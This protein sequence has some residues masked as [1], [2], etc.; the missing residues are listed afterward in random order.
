[1]AESSRWRGPE[2]ARDFVQALRPIASAAVPALPARQAVLLAVGLAAQPAAAVPTGR[3]NQS[4]YWP[5]IQSRQ[6]PRLR[7]PKAIS[8]WSS[9]SARG[10]TS[11]EAFGFRVKRPV[12][13]VSRAIRPLARARARSGL[14]KDERGR[15]RSRARDP[16]LACFRRAAVRVSRPWPA[17]PCS[18]QAHRHQR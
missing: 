5:T 11:K 18:D 2:P 12:A 4:T 3:S 17:R 6:S 14:Y 9:S 8:S 13:R 1:M 15:P 10:R 16:S 7:R